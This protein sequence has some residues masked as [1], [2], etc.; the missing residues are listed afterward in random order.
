MEMPPHRYAGFWKRLAAY[1]WDSLIVTILAIVLGAIL[2]GDAQALTAQDIQTLVD[3]GLLPPGT[4][5]QTLLA[6]GVSDMFGGIFSLS[7]A[8]IVAM[9][10]AV[11]NIGFVA[12]TWQA[13]PGKRFC[14]I[15]VVTVDGGRLTLAQSAIRHAGSG[16]SLLMFGVGFLT[17]VLTRQK[18][19][20]HDVLANTRVVYATLRP[21]NP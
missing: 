7:N 10:S 13:T 1:G 18:T 19:A 15:Q 8:F 4:N 21:V 14:G 6:G 11:Y 5:T 9:V 20:L 3:A 16:L 2:G 12:S 17:I